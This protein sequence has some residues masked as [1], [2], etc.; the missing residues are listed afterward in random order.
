M[1]LPRLLICTPRSEEEAETFIRNHIQHLPF[2]VIVAH[3][4]YLPFMV[5]G[6]NPRA[7][8]ER[9][10][11]W[12]ARLMRKNDRVSF[13]RQR[14]FRQILK[15]NDVDYVLAEYML[16]GAAIADI[17]SDEGIPFMATGLGYEMSVY[18]VL[19][20]KE[21]HY[22]N[23]LSKAHHTVVVSKRMMDTLERFGGQRGRMTWSPAGPAEGFFQLR[24]T[25]EGKD[26]F[27][28]GRFVD[29]KAPHLLILMWQQ[30]I[31]RH[32]DARLFI[33]G[34]GPMFRFCED[35]VRVMGLESN[36]RLL[37][38]IDQEEQK[39]RLEASIGFIQHSRVAQDGDSEGT[40]VAILEAM[41]A[42][43]PVVSTHHSGIPD[44]IQDG[45]TGFLSAE[46]DVKGMLSK[47]L[48][49]IED[50]DL[51]KRCSA[52][53]RQVVSE[54]FTLKQHLE[55]ITAIIEQGISDS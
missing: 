30:L 25:L 2:H 46:N 19:E 15:D 37:G 7:S 39:R 22:R 9:W 23:Y 8:K 21:P 40:P 38:R 51:R 47:V 41:A 29:K 4:D 54:R 49:L 43:V 20:D 13:H 50:T 1:S 34:D 24:P 16:S 45:Q 3:G 36:V 55:T 52:A 12:I 28:L 5:D 44:I 17:C 32:P 48:D 14:A 26:F 11:D 31:E 6:V 35:L 18:K 42:S 33:G 27:A 10:D 53:A